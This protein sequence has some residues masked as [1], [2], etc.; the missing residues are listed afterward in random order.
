MTARVTA[1]YRYPVKGLSAEKMDRVTLKPGECLPHDRRFAIAL[2]STAFDPERPEW[3]SKIHFIML[4]RDEKLARLQSRFDPESG[5]LEISD[6]GRVVLHARMTAPEG[7]RLVAEFFT[8]FL[9][10]AANGPLRGAGARLR[11]RT[12]QAECDHR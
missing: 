1:I 5:I 8:N 12:A 7:C 9:G 2:P 6:K 4:M 11:R 10:D 3:L